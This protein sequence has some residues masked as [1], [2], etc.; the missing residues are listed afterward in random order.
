MEPVFLGG[1]ASWRARHWMARADEAPERYV[2]EEFLPLSH[3]PAWHEGASR[4]A[5]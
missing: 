4:A 1:V 5:R 3:A 2:L